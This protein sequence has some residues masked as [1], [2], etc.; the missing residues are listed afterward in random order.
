MRQ[1]ARACHH[2]TGDRPSNRYRAT[3]VGT[4]TA[5]SRFAR[6]LV[7]YAHKPSGNASLCDVRSRA[8]KCGEIPMWSSSEL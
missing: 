5:R 2:I 1:L 3:V 6:A 8:A 4:G 7:C